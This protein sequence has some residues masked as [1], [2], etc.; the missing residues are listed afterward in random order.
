MSNRVRTIAALFPLLVAASGCLFQGTVDA[1]GGAELKMH[2]RLDPNAKIDKVGADLQSKDVKLVSKSLDS[3]HYVDA[4]LQMADVTKLPTTA[5]FKATTVKL[6]DGSEKGTK[7]LTV[8]YMNPKPMD[9]I[10]S[11]LLDYYGKDVQVVLNLP[12]NVVKSNA[13]EVKGSSAT[14]TLDTNKFFAAKETLFEV[15][16]KLGQ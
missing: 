12:G 1:K 16:Y 15:T 5:F 11:T 7:T 6:A 14:W 13:T 4:T 2:Y 9:K 10:P 8:K 3:E